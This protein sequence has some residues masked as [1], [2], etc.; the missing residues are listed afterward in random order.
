MNKRR[1]K[2]IQQT[3]AALTMAAP[4][5]IGLVLFIAGPFLLAA[6]LS[7]TNLRL[8]SPLPTE[9]LGL[10]QYRRILSDPVF[11]RALLNNAIFAA[12]VV[13]LQTVTALCVALLLNKKLA[14]MTVFRTLFF[15]PVVFP[16][17]MVAIVWELIYA[18]GP[19]GS[20]NSSLE[21]VTLGAW[22]P[23]NFLH[24]PVF[25]LPALMV[26]SIWQ[27]MG[28][29]M[30][31]LLAGLQSIPAVHYE[32]AEIDGASSWN[33]FWHITLPELRNPLIFVVLVTCILAFR[34]FDQVQILTQG[35]PQ[36]ATTTV[37]FQ[38]VTAAFSRQQVAR[39]CAMTVVFFVIV[40]LLTGLQRLL[41]REERQVV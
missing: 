27:G 32:A 15:M 33:Q 29:Q 34:L 22:E 19:N 6:F 25:A 21:L 24:E 13:P 18:P 30:I 5:L 41:I 40:L 11:L 8:G 26:L 28:F 39:A 16:M 3:G 1:D 37:M 23:H 31:V 17:A 4:A 9:F 20:L 36:Y 14:G 10:E 12:V 38:A 2:P 35:G 7:L